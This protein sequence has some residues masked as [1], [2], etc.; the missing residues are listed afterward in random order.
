MQTKLRS[1][2]INI[3]K[4]HHIKEEHK[5]IRFSHVSGWFPQVPLE[6]VAPFGL[7]SLALTRTPFHFSLFFF[8]RPGLQDSS[9]T[10]RFVGLSVGDPVVADPF[11]AGD[12]SSNCTS[13]MTPLSESCRRSSG[14]D[15]QKINRGSSGL[16]MFF[17]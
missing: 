15:T 8:L 4:E 3:K 2:T 11:S 10:L 12:A 6:Q 16:N 13:A 17:K 5:D 7:A 9:L 1:I 14:A